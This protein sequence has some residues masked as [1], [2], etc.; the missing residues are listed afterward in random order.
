MVYFKSKFL[1]LEN[2]RRYIPRQS[3][4]REFMTFVLQVELK[5]RVFEEATL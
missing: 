3:R 4:Q 2:V 5:M 1:H